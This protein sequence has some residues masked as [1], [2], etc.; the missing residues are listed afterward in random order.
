MLRDLY[1]PQCSAGVDIKFK[2]KFNPH[3][4]G[5]SSQE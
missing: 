4:T 2:L 5:G 1:E 3:P